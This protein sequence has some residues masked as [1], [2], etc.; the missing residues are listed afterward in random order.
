MN[1]G[2]KGRTALVTGASK[3]IG[4]AIARGLADEGVNL[5]LVAR[6]QEDLDRAA[7]EIC[8]ATGVRVVAVPT[9]IR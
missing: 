4:K 6:G 7:A 5:V 9:D 1:L 2:L 3:G 8:K